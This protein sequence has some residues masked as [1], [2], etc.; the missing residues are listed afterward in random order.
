[1]LPPALKYDLWVLRSNRHILPPA[2]E[3][4]LRA[5]RLTQ[6]HSFTPLLL[7]APLLALQVHAVLFHMESADKADLLEEHVLLLVVSHI[8]S[9]GWSE[10]ICIDEVAAA[11]NAFAQGGHPPAHGA[12]PDL[13]AN[14]VDYCFWQ[15]GRTASGAALEAQVR[16]TSTPEHHVKVHHAFTNPG[17]ISCRRSICVPICWLPTTLGSTPLACHI[18]RCTFFCRGS[19]G[20]K[21]WRA[22]PASPASGRTLSCR[23]A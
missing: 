4:D 19:T 14:W 11:Y 13:P 6:V 22:R 8:C 5:L 2:L 16:L 1:M 23:Q 17:L 20:G 7:T 9:D 21:L 3:H 10:K 18:R 15:R 12:L